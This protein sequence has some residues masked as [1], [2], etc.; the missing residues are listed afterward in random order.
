M[1]KKLLFI[2]LLT[3][4]GLSGY[5]QTTF[6]QTFVD[7]CTGEVKVVTA[8]FVNGSATVAFYN[9]VRVFTYQEAVNGTLQ[10]WLNETF[11][12]WSALSPCSVTTQQT[13]QAQQTAQTA[14]QAA[15]TAQAEP[16]YH[17]ALL[18]LLTVPSRTVTW[19]R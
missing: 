3:L 17:S 8:T 16:K 13:Q 10:I 2:L 9:K 4:I 15:Q 7:R 11:A 5:G 18:Q 19:S 12:W 6:T 1:A 14:Q